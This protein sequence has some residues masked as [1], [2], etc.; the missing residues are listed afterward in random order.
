MCANA[1]LIENLSFAILPRFGEQ[2]DQ[3]LHSVGVDELHAECDLKGELSR[4]PGRRIGQRQQ[5]LEPAFQVLCG[6]DVRR[7][8]GCPL[9]RAMK[10]S[11]AAPSSNR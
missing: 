10:I 6:L 1:S 11:S 8:L 7:L 4:G 9:P 5:Q 3:P 2:F